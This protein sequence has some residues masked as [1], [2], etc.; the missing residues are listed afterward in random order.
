MEKEIRQRF[1]WVRLYEEFEDAGIVCRC[2]GISRSTLRKWWNRYQAQGLA[3]LKN[4]SRRPH[5]S[6]AAK[7]GSD[8]EAA[9]FGIARK[10]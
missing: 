7:I 3:G 1:Q 6:P 10:T 8:Y 5:N 2:C 9:C 4:Q